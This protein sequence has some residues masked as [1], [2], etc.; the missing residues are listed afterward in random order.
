MKEKEGRKEGG[1]KGK[2]KR[3]NGNGI[4]GFLIYVCGYKS[5]SKIGN[6]QGA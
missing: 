3:G 6:A 2:G 1:I 5:G 4:E